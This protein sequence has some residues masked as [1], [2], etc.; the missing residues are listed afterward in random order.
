MDFTEVV[1]ASETNAGGEVSPRPTVLDSPAAVE[2]FASGLEGRLADEI[3]SAAV[4]AD[5]PDGQVLVG[6]VV[7]LG[8]DV[9]PG[10]G[11]TRTPEGIEVT[12]LKVAKPKQEC[13]APVTSVSLLTVDADAV[14]NG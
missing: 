10:V 11:V 1:L 7:A 2:D 3:R 4:D 8:C 9:P 14:T 13:F 6:A 12:A 5:V